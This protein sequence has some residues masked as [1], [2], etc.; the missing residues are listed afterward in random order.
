MAILPPSWRALGHTASS[1]PILLQRVP[2][3]LRTF[4]INAIPR[5]PQTYFREVAP[6]RGSPPEPMLF[7]RRVG[8]HRCPRDSSLT[9]AIAPALVL[10]PQNRTACRVTLRRSDGTGKQEEY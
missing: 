1:A 8:V 6:L 9:V 4:R 5:S 7:C 3:N 10:D 2:C